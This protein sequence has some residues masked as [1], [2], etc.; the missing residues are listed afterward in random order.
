MVLTNKASRRAGPPNLTCLI[1]ATCQ[2]L[3]SLQLVL[4]AKGMHKVQSQHTTYR[5]CP[6]MLGYD[7]QSHYLLPSCLG[8]EGISKHKLSC[9]LETIYTW[10]CEINIAYLCWLVTPNQ[11]NS[12]YL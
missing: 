2:L 4:R 11:F 7:T 6:H 1:H 5:S 9:A 8:N 12:C 10:T 3:G